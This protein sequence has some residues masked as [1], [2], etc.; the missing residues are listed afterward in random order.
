MASAF[1]VWIRWGADQSK[2]LRHTGVGLA[3][4][5]AWRVFDDGKVQSEAGCWI[6]AN[7]ALYPQ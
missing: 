7:P 1:L 4:I 6:P 3:G 2:K 5:Q